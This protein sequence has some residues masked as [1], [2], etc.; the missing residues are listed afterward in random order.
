[1]SS[2]SFTANQVADNWTRVDKVSII[3][4]TNNESNNLQNQYIDFRMSSLSCNSCSRKAA[5]ESPELDKNDWTH[6][7]QHLQ[8][9]LQSALDFKTH[10]PNK[11][12]ALTTQ[13]L[14]N[15][16]IKDG[17][18]ICGKVKDISVSHKRVIPFCKELVKVARRQQKSRERRFSTPKL[19]KIPN[20]HQ[21]YVEWS[22]PVNSTV[23]PST[24]QYLSKSKVSPTQY[25]E[26]QLQLPETAKRNFKKLDLSW[27]QIM[28]LE[29][30][31]LPVS[32][33][34]P[35]VNVPFKLDPRIPTLFDLDGTSC[36]WCETPQHVAYGVALILQEDVRVIGVEVERNRIATK[37]VLIQ[38]ATTEVVILIPTNIFSISAQK[39]LHLIF[40]DSQ[41]FKVGVNIEENLWAL[42]VDFQIESNS[43][44]ELNEL[45]QFSAKKFNSFPGIFENLL[46]LHAIASF[47]GYQDWGSQQLMFTN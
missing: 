32:R 11:E 19:R 21:E 24:K 3:P 7:G 26:S 15:P 43:F 23:N 33:L 12:F 10:R 25:L 1:M 44:V 16:P 17:D 40:R 27:N 36:Y 47:L 18:L 9:N 4:G 46:D 5:M 8:K 39:A 6:F 37:V 29:S 30:S 31:G 34:L 14:A 22:N 38:I 28:G 42:W 45:L 13:E 41:I 20:A 35:N 2:I